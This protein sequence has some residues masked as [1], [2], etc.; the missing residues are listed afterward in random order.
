MFSTSTSQVIVDSPFQFLF[1]GPSRIKSTPNRA[2]PEP[3]PAVV[4][5]VASLFSGWVGGVTYSETTAVTVVTH[6]SSA[7][8][9]NVTLRKV[10]SLD[11]ESIAPAIWPTAEE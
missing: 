7:V 6:E 10:S 4:V 11:P 2:E 5:A 9:D 3:S 1:P 8:C